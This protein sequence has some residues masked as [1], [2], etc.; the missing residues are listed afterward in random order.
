M[1]LLELNLSGNPQLRLLKF[2]L[3]FENDESRELRDDVVRSF[4]SICESVTSNFLVV[5]VYGLPKEWE[6][7]SSIQDMLLALS[8]R[9][10]SFHFYLSERHWDDEV[11]VNRESIRELFSKLYEKEV[12]IEELLYD[13]QSVSHHF[14][15]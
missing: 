14:Q 10:E 7:C 9:V 15:I 8:A 6:V 1:P 2:T 11:S 4:N 13:S 5:E 12:V 3:C